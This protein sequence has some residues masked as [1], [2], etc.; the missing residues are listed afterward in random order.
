MY[1]E[2][3]T[4]DWFWGPA[5]TKSW[6]QCNLESTCG[7]IKTANGSLDALLGGRKAYGFEPRP[8]TEDT[9]TQQSRENL[10]VG[11]CTYAANH[12]NVF[13]QR[14]PPSMRLPASVK[15]KGAK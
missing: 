2:S 13:P 5:F 6:K 7:D 1:V 15:P 10:V 14:P 4:Q 12:K 8:G 3:V 9:S 11:P